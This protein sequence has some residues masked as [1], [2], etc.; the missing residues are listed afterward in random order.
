MEEEMMRMRELEGE[1]MEQEA[2]EEAWMRRTVVPP[3]RRERRGM[4]GAMMGGRPFD[5]EMM[6]RREMERAMMAERRRHEEIRRHAERMRILGGMEVDDRAELEQR[7]RDMLEEARNHAE[8][9]EILRWRGPPEGEMVAME[10]EMER[11]RRGDQDPG[12]GPADE[13]GMQMQ[14][15]DENGTRIGM[16]EEPA[17]RIGMREEEMMNWREMEGPEMRMRMRDEAANPGV[18]WGR[19]GWEGEG[20]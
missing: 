19:R 5:Q 9:M 20:G 11:R 10:A 18:R 14:M 8:N 7:Q 13:E 3:P 4:E 15:I 2:A 6:A 17:M 12:M 1:P 16:M